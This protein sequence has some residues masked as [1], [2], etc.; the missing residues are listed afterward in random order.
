[1]QRT[2][3][4][5]LFALLVL[6]T[7]TASAAAQSLNATLSGIVRDSSGG[8]LPGVTVTARQTATNQ[9]R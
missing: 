5:S 2:H 9:T 6:T 4:V 8:V 3:L 1:M 7:L